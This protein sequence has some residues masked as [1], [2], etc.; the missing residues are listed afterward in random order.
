MGYAQ[1]QADLNVEKSQ[2]KNGEERDKRARN[3]DASVWNI[4]ISN[5][6]Y[7]TNWSSIFTYLFLGW[8]KGF[9]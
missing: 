7:P 6:P 4:L 3:F 8:Y 2:Q 1:F 9:S 5:T